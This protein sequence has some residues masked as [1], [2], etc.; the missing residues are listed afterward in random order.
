VYVYGSDFVMNPGLEI[1]LMVARGLAQAVPDI[2][3]V[4]VS[5][6]YGDATADAVVPAVRIAKNSVDSHHYDTFKEAEKAD[7]VVTGLGY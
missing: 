3:I 1:M 2:K 7:A 6:R 5:D 4:Y